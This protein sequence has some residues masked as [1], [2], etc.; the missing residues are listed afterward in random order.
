MQNFSG[1]WELK[2]HL[3]IFWRERVQQEKGAEPCEMVVRSLT[4]LRL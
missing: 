3:A 1:F 4:G 2:D